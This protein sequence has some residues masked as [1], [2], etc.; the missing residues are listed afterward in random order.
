M[1][2][3]IQNA[4][5]E[6]KIY[7][8]KHMQAGLCGYDNETVL[9]DN[10]TIK[11]MVPSFVGKP[12]YIHHQKVDLENLKEQANGYVVESFFNDLDSWSWVKII[13]I[14]DKA[15]DVVGKGW[16]VSNAYVPTQFS[17]PGEQHNVPYDREI[18]AGYF[19]H[20]AIVPNPRYE[21][22][23]IFT[24]E[25]FKAYQ[26]EKRAKL[27]EIHN[28]KT[29]ASKMIFKKKA[30]KEEKVITKFEDDDVIEFTNSK[31]ETVE[32]SANDMLKAVTENLN[33]K[34]KKNADDEKEKEEKMNADTMVMVGDKSWKMG[35]LIAYYG[36]MANAEEK[37]KE[38]DDE[39]EAVENKKTKKNSEGD[40]DEVA[41]KKK[42][43]EEKENA[44]HFDELRNANRKAEQQVIVVDMPQDQLR[45]GSER[46]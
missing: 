34:A 31:G 32:V 26:A 16:S 41:K 28:S 13:V 8:A 40:E 24:P 20:L 23:Q 12:V 11:A 38:N 33:A 1:P 6:P 22:A 42:D 18:T 5:Q 37:E 30:K 7:F 35:D 46:Y 9:I 25:A 10:D 19:T 44:K 4:S 2:T 29:G 15:H 36:E 39:D 3:E 27:D 43:D 14:D 17:G 45:R 21:D